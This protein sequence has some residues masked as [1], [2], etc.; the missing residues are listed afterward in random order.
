MSTNLYLKTLE[1]CMLVVTTATL[2]PRT[3]KALSQALA[4]VPAGSS[5]RSPR[6]SKITL[7]DDKRRGSEPLGPEARIRLEKLADQVMKEVDEDAAKRIV[8]E[9]LVDGE[10]VADHAFLTSPTERGDTA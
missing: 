10:V 2:R 3:L 8:Q 1:L 4:A 6:G 5:N 9:H 7:L